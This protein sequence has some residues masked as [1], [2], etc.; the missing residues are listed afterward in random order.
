MK[1]DFNIPKNNLIETDDYVV[2]DPKT[3]I[4]QYNFTFHMTILYKC[5]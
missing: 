5:I 2:I 4:E 3:D 1:M